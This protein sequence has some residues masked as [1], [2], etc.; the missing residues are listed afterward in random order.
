[1]T[2]HSAKR[3]RAQEGIETSR[4]VHNL[5]TSAQDALVASGRLA[6]DP[7]NEEESSSSSSSDVAAQ[8]AQAGLRLRPKGARPC[9]PKV[10]AAP[11]MLGIRR[12][13]DISSQRQERRQRGLR[14][15]ALPAPVARV[16]Q[17][18]TARGG[19]Q[20]LPLFQENAQT[21]RKSR[22]DS[23]KR[24]VTAQ[25]LQ[26]DEGHQWH[27]ERRALFQQGGAT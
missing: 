12:P 23:T 22:A 19:V 16:L 27:N 10:V 14:A 24:N 4:S 15:M 9:D 18:A 21:T 25:W 13:A 8:A 20:G 26:S 1:M 11:D 3:R 5:R 17:E 2:H 7:G 6:H